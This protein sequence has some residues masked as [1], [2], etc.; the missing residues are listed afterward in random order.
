MSRVK[1][2]DAGNTPFLPGELINVKYAKLIND[3]LAER[4]KQ[5]IFYTP[6]LL[7][8]TKAS[9]TTESF[10]SAA[11]FQETTRV[12]TQAAIEGKLIGYVV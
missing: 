3:M 5:P 12:L 6:V 4:D 8:L 10:I 2:K 9:L 7:G 1:I 11:S